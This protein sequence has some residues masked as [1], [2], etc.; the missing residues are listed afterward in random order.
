MAEPAAIL[1]LRNL[2]G[3]PSMEDYPDT[4]LS[5]MIDSVDGDLNR[6]AAQGWG[7]IAAGYT[8]LVNV[9][10]SGS[11]R[12]LGDL[13]KNAMAMRTYYDSLGVEGVTRGRTRIGRIVR[14]HEDTD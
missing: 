7:Y 2:L 13:Y 12:N 3:N 10:E 4:L 9:T 1:Q 8:T 5:N 14:T 11:T 6:A